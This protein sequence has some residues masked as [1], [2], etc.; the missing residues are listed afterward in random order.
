MQDLLA[1]HLHINYFHIAT[2]FWMSGYHHVGV[3]RLLIEYAGFKYVLN[4][5]L[6]HI[7]KTIFIV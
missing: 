4:S 2:R 1:Q 6:K 5:K 3:G 7:F